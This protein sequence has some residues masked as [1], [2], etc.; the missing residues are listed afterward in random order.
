[1]GGCDLSTMIRVAQI[2]HGICL[3]KE[4][5][6]T[7][8]ESN[9]FSWASLE[10]VI[11]SIYRLK[12]PVVIHVV[13]DI[14]RW[15]LFSTSVF[16]TFHD[17]SQLFSIL[18]NLYQPFSTFVIFSTNDF[19]SFSKKNHIHNL[20]GLVSLILS[21][22]CLICDKFHVCDYRHRG[23]ICRD[24]LNSAHIQSLDTNCL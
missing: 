18:H 21:A 13:W 19:F 3:F 9:F 10:D 8:L 14:F 22:Y 5:L 6:I 12:T 24:I 16:F 20:Q 17:M 23:F 15:K 1:M 2:R 11:L 4:R 7:L